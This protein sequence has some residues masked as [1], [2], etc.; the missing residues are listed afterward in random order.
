MT[1]LKISLKTSAAIGCTP[2]YLESHSYAPFGRVT[3][4]TDP[5]FGFGRQPLKEKKRNVG[6]DVFA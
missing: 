5:D 1:V 2:K 3:Q 6:H 4:C